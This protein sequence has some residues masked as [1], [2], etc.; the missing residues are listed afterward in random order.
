MHINQWMLNP[1]ASPPPA[2]LNP[3]DTEKPDQGSSWLIPLLSGVAFHSSILIAMLLIV[4]VRESRRKKIW[5]QVSRD[6]YSSK[7]SI[8]IH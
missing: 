2:T 5:V 3:L 4:G 8:Q 7:T 6:S 1:P